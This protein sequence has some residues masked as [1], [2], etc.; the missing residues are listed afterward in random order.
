MLLRVKHMNRTIKELEEC[1]EL[2]GRHTPEQKMSSFY[3]Y[4]CGM[5]I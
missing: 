1:G 2:Q 3:H 4:L 5:F